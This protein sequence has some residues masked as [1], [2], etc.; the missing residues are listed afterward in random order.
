LVY[1]SVAK[2]ALRAIYI[3]KVQ[4]DTSTSIKRIGK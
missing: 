2:R 4:H 1:Y 3:S